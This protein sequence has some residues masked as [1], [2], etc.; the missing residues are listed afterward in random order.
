MYGIEETEETFFYGFSS[1]FRTQCS[2][3]DTGETI[4]IHKNSLLNNM[5]M[6]IIK[7]RETKANRISLMKSILNAE[8][9]MASKMSNN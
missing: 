2:I 1:L 8:R 6:H 5:K 9:D 3:N 7:R 4:T